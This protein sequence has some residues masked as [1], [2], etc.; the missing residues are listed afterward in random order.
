MKRKE[1]HPKKHLF[2]EIIAGKCLS[3]EDILIALGE[4]H[5]KQRLKLV[6][7]GDNPQKYFLNSE[8]IS[9]EKYNGLIQQSIKRGVRIPIKIYVNGKELS[10]QTK[11]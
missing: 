10:K 3:K 6:I 7:G 9:R 1:L 2:K 5:D 11:Q 4:N 8:P